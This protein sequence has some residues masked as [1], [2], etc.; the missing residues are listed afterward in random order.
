MPEAVVSL[1]MNCRFETHDNCKSDEA[2]HP[3]E[4]L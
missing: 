1:S 4:Q 2:L 3:Q